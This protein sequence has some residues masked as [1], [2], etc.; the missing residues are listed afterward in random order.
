MNCQYQ[1]LYTIM[2]GIMENTYI[3]RGKRK[4]VRPNMTT[5][6]AISP[7]AAFENVYLNCLLMMLL[8]ITKRYR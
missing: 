2:D 1:C 7:T 5:F 6:A 8:R 3:R 4:Y